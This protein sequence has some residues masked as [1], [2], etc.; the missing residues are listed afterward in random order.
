ML[1][2]H[3]FS[4]KSIFVLQYLDQISPSLISLIFCHKLFIIITSFEHLLRHTVILNFL[5]TL[6]Q[7]HFFNVFRDR[8]RKRE[9]KRKRETLM[10]ERNINGLPS[11]TCPDWGLNLQSGYVPWLGMESAIFQFWDNAPTNWATLATAK[12][13]IRHNFI[14]TNLLS[15]LDSEF[16]KNLDFFFLSSLH[17]QSLELQLAHGRDSINIL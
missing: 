4:S 15:S 7:G 13:Y 17:T 3:C 10:W 12:T 16:H 8:G 6:T 2:H 1:F 5:K 14:F 11:H 9:T